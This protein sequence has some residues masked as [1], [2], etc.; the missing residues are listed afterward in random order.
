VI[1]DI[2]MNDSN[3]NFK[4]VCESLGVEVK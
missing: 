1:M 4:A 3:S 2:L